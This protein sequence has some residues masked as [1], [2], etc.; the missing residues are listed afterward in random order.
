MT[1]LRFHLCTLL[2]A[3]E[4]WLEAARALQGINLESS[5]RALNDF[6][7][8]DT[9]IRI[10]RLH[11]ESDDP[12]QADVFLKRASHLLSIATD[13]ARGGGGS[14]TE[15]ERGKAK[16]LLLSYKLCQARIYDSQRRFLDAAAR[17]HELSYVAEIDDEER[18]Q[19][20]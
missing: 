8:L 1:P 13:A 6:A 17:F 19:M 12:V 3:E 16:V 7:R 2:E 14:Y 20:L 15:E 9:Y 5:N 11:L 10:A 18:M 4:D